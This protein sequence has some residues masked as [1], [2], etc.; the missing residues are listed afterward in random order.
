MG[1]LR[2]LE[3]LALL[4]V[5][6]AFLVAVFAVVVFFAGAF[7]VVDLVAVFFVAVL[8]PVLV[9]VLESEDDLGAA[10]FTGPEGPI[11]GRQVSTENDDEVRGLWFGPSRIG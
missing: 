8:A 11:D 6:G 7:L 4:L 1:V 3:V 2:T 9:A 5:A 10:S